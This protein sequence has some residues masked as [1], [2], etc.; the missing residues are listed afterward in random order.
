M[1]EKEFFE[2]YQ[3]HADA[4]FRHCFFWIR[5]REIAKDIMQDTF[6]KTWEHIAKGEIIE[7]IR[8]FLY[9]V[10]YNTLIDYTRKQREYSLEELEDGGAVFKDATSLS[11]QEWAQVK[12]IVNVIDKQE[13][14]YKDILSLHF[15]DGLKNREIASILEISEN[16]VAVRLHR[17][18][19][20]VRQVLQEGL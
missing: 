17:G 10:A 4:I 11:P 19:E 12:E 2:A 16:V 1:H 13:K 9:K 7:N 15:I 3:K 14:I 6:K 20:K 18:I 5:N 8:P